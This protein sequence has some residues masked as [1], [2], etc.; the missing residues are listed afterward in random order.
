MTRQHSER[1]KNF[2][3]SKSQKGEVKMF[4]AFSQSEYGSKKSA[5]SKKSKKKG[6]FSDRSMS[7]KN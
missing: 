2:K 3:I 4:D 1:K 6:P 7:V 5:I